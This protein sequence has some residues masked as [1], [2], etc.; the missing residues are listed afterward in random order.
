[1]LI[2]FTLFQQIVVREIVDAHG[3]T[4]IVQGFG[5]GFSCGGAAFFQDVV[6]VRQIFL[7]HFP[8]VTDRF[9]FGLDDVVQELLD[10]DV[11]QAAAAGSGLSARPG[12]CSPAGTLRSVPGRLNAS[13]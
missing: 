5:G 4:D 12:C 3:V 9:E 10:F 6:Y 7:P 13:R 8:T 11:A 2:C 1:M